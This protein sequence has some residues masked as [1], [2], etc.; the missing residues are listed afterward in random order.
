MS[1]VIAPDASFDYYRGDIYWNN[2]HIVNSHHNYIISGRPT[3]DWVSFLRKT[4]T[5]QD[6][7]FLNCGNG[8]VERDLF[9]AG[10]IKKAT[11]CD[12]NEQL[13]GQAAAA[14]EQAGLEASYFCADVNTLDDFGKRF[15]L[16][17]NFA[18]V[19]HVA[20]I[21][22]TMDLMSK[23]TGP[24][25]LYVTYD[26]VGPHR[27]QYSVEAWAECA[28]IRLALPA[29]YR[30]KLRYPHMKTMLSLDPSEAVH[31]ELQET[32]QDRFFAR[33][34][35]R[36]LGGAILYP[37]L[38]GNRC[39]FDEQE[40]NEGRDA[41]QFLIEADT[42]FF[43]KHPETNLFTFS[44]SKSK[45]AT[46]N[47]GTRDHWQDEENRR[48]GRAT[49]NSG[50]YYPPTLL[51]LIYNEIYSQEALDGEVSTPASSM[52]GPP[53]ENEPSTSIDID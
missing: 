8:W 25:G 50:R 20:Y 26:Y 29:K 48:E 44:V 47:P 37:L 49:L 5:E 19:H 13:L 33:V 38:Y 18:A 22:R 21:N 46:I 15:D 32:V 45:D 16:V 12:I 2:F 4:A 6:A 1:A 43:A 27:N 52:V 9:Q 14:A 41:L 24:D 17:V 11:G 42:D 7:F 39:L 34:V 23:L 35:S 36:K 51:E 31:A 10:V 3:M 40:T 53:L 30:T 28:R